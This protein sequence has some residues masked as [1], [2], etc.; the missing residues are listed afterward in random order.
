MKKLIGIILGCILLVGC[1]NKIDYNQKSMSLALGMSKPQVSSILGQ[2]RR[3]DVNE[4][5]ERWIYWNPVMVGFTPV[6]NEQLAGDRLVVT[7]VDGKVS[8]W[9]QQTLA[10]DM[11]E[12]TQKLYK[13]GLDN[14]RQVQ[15]Q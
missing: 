1:A 8:R 13:Q 14:A 3:T 10:D 4:E 11:M 9:G 5:R 7:F 2:P 15:A 12:N 6:D